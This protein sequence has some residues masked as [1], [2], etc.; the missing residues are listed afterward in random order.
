MSLIPSRPI[1]SLKLKDLGSKLVYPLDEALG[2]DIL[3]NK[4]TPRAMLE[5]CK[6]VQSSSSLDSACSSLSKET[7]IVAN[8]VTMRSVAFT[9][10][11]MI[12]EQDNEETLK[13]LEAYADQKVPSNNYIHPTIYISL[14][15][16]NLYIRNSELKQ[17]SISYPIQLGLIFSAE[18]IRFL[19]ENLQ[20]EEDFTKFVLTNKEFLAQIGDAETF[21]KRLLASAYRLVDCLPTNTVILTDASPWIKTV[22]G[23][24]FPE[25][26]VIFDFTVLKKWLLSFAKTNLNPKEVE[27]W[28]SMVQSYFRNSH[29]LEALAEIKLVSESRFR[30]FNFLLK[31]LESHQDNLDYATFVKNGYLIG[32]GAVEESQRDALRERLT[33]QGMRWTQK[34]GQIILTLMSKSLSGRWESDVEALVLK[35]FCRN[36][37]NPNIHYN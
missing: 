31:T 10:G 20:E 24:I 6:R 32:T 2:F 18:N 22:K 35:K 17:E 14:S 1:D 23:T 15:G 34:S 16:S 11:N 13:T 5:I 33:Q 28:T 3:P 7:S 37:P 12:I 29:T 19:K 30:R 21:S 27:P 8:Q 36:A 26:K 25:A 9:I 4:L